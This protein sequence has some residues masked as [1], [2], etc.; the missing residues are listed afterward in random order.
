MGQHR[1]TVICYIFRIFG[2]TLT[3]NRMEIPQN[4]VGHNQ[5][6]YDSQDRKREKTRWEIQAITYIIS[7]QDLS[8]S[9]PL[10]DAWPILYFLMQIHQ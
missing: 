7:R 4:W 6:L 5:I 2:Q 3:F 10:P 9:T 8:V 1:V